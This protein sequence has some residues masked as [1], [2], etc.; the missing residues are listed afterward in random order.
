M[1]EHSS[2]HIV[3]ALFSYSIVA[4]SVPNLLFSKNLTEKFV[5]VLI[6]EELRGNVVAILLFSN[7]LNV[8]TKIV[9]ECLLVVLE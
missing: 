1:E 6:M 9:I 4:A 3:G 8:G 7:K 5:I 2:N